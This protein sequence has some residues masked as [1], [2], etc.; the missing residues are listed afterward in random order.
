MEHKEEIPLKDMWRHTG[1][2]ELKNLF[3]ALPIPDA[4]DYLREH[5]RSLADKA[6]EPVIHSLAVQIFMAITDKY[7][8]STDVL[9][10]PAEFMKL[11]RLDTPIV[12]VEIKIPKDLP[13]WV[14]EMAHIEANLIPRKYLPFTRETEEVK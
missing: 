1:T 11:N 10:N 4:T 9:K 7:A 8:S 6:L 5:A 14:C 2:H 13:Q 3:E 12:Q